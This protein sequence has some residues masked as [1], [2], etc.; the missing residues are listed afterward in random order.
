MREVSSIQPQWLH[1]IA[2]HF[3]DYKPKHVQHSESTKKILEE[4]KIHRSIF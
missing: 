2:P 3:Y 1:E 4:D